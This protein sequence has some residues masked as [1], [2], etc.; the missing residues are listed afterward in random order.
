MYLSKCMNKNC[1]QQNPILAICP[2][3]HYLCHEFIDESVH[4]VWL[5]LL[6][7]NDGHGV[8]GHRVVVLER[9]QLCYLSQVS[10]CL[11]GERFVGFEQLR[12]S[13]WV[14]LLRNTA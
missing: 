6:S 13:I 2:A 10:P 3:R 7:V 14:V 8:K 11:L 1:I 12:D 4:E 5:P 9:Q